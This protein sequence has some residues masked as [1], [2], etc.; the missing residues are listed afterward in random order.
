MDTW[1]KALSGREADHSPSCSAEVSNECDLY[2]FPPF[3]PTWRNGT[4]LLLLF[5]L[6]GLKYHTETEENGLNFSVSVE[7]CFSCSEA[8]SQLRAAKVC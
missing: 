1:G 7:V 8:R 3:P 2:F 4:A 6:V 5:C